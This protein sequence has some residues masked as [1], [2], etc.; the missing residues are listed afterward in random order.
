MKLFKRIKAACYV[1]DPQF[2]SVTILTI[3]TEMACVTSHRNIPWWGYV[4]GGLFWP[5]MLLIINF[6]TPIEKE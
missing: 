1:N 4:V 2:T 3:L 5:T 6:I